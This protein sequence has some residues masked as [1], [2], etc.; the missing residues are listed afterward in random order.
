MQYPGWWCYGHIYLWCFSVLLAHVEGYITECMPYLFRAGW[1]TGHLWSY[2]IS[3]TT[4][5]HDTLKLCQQFPKK[6]NEKRMLPKGCTNRFVQS[7]WYGSWYSSY[8]GSLVCKILHLIMTKCYCC[9]ESE[10]LT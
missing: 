3:F 9:L 8:E 4:N 10:D 5:A 2:H 1:S 6:R 7:S